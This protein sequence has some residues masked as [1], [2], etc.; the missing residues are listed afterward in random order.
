MG[1][2]TF[3]GGRAHTRSFVAR[4]Q[5]FLWIALGIIVLVLIIWALKPST[6]HSARAG[7]FGASGPMPVGVATAQSGDMRVTLNAL[8]TVTPLATVTVRPQ[9]S[10]QL[11]RILF[12]E[13]QMAKAGEL[14][15]EI[16]PR[17]YQAAV[18]QAKGTLA[19]D[20]AVLDNAKADLARYQALFNLKAI[21]QQTLATQQSL[22]QQDQGVIVSDQANVEAAAVNLA[23]TKITSPVNGRVGLRQVDIG[24]LVTAGQTDGIVVVTEL[25][26]ISVVFTLPEDNIDAVMAQ[27]RAGD[28]LEADAYDRS[29]TKKLATGKL[30]TID[31][32]I[33]TTTGTVKLRALFDNADNALFPNQFVNIRLLVQT[34]H[35]QTIVPAAAVQRGAEGSYVFAVKPDKTVSMRTVTVGV[36]DGDKV[37]VTNGLKP[38]DTVVIDGADRLRDG[39]EVTLPN[40]KTQKITEPSAAPA[41]SAAAV[42]HSGRHGMFALMRKVTAEEREKLHAMSRADRS[43]WLKA[44]QN[45]LQKR[46]D[47]PGGFGGGGGPPP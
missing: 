5:R 41:G 27:T 7:R 3:V 40:A 26:P 38:G 22:V 45:E 43:A 24:N 23:Y 30:S 39:A 9:V 19:K 31:N 4:N 20:Q 33:D 29:Q 15:A 16:D 8:G 28:T 35:N 25:Q 37:A 12:Q 14:L 32:Q 34:L 36:T 46:P 47:Q 21:A 2:R 44:H 10:G 1:E 6:T 13:G 42:A 17:S 11:S 18:D